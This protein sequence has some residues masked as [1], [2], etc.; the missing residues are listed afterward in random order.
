MVTI[1]ILKLKES[2]YYVGKTT[3][4]N[5]RLENHINNSGCAWTKLYPPIGIISIHENCDDFD[6]D[7]YTLKTMSQYGIDNVRGGSYVNI[8][9]ST[10]QISA[11][12]QMV[13]GGKNL[14]FKCGSSTHYI[15]KCPLKNQ[16]NKD[17]VINEK[18]I[19]RQKQNKT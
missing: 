8:V 5:Q 6:E 18:P 19:Q 15:T 4:I 11:I 16:K 10:D 13:K 17:T 3:D 9:L 14:C 2:K 1:Y 7:K 12:I